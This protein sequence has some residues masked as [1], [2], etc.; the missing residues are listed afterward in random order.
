MRVVF[1]SNVYYS[2][3]R[4]ARGGSRI[5]LQLV[6]FGLVRLCSN[7]YIFAEIRKNIIKKETEAVFQR[8]LQLIENL[9]YIPTDINLIQARQE[10]KGFIADED[11]V[12]I[13][14]IAKQAQ[15]DYLV[16]LDKRHF[17]K[18]KVRQALPIP[19]VSPAQ[20]IEIIRKKLD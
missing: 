5:L 11:D 15:A 19:I 20:M 8:Y 16:T 3:V 1:D 10:F 6:E 13:L 14:A 2:A 9:S 12:A 4:S 7:D 17:F 18:P